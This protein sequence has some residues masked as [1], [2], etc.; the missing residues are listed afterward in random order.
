VKLEWRPQ[1]SDDRERIM[2]FIAQDNPQ[3]ALDLDTL[4]EEKAG[5]LIE[6]PK[7]FKPGRMKNTREA[8]V[9]PNYVLVYEASGST[10]TILRVLHTS[11]AWPATKKT[12][13]AK[14]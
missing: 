3:A 1:A 5:S 12:N 14:S 13:V 10:V 4:F 11:Q 8:V 9:H 7:L 6:Q 2:D